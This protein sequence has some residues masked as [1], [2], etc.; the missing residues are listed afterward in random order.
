MD[1][2]SFVAEI[3]YQDTL[4]PVIDPSPSSLQTEEEDSFALLAWVV[5]S[6]HSHD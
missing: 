5:A 2:S 3:S 4:D 1:M 6:S